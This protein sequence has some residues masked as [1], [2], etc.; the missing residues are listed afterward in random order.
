MEGTG[1]KKIGER[2]FY[3]DVYKKPSARPARVKG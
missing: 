3:F 1:S 2:Y